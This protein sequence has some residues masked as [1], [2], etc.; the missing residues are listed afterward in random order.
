[1]TVAGVVIGAKVVQRERNLAGRVRAIQDGD[2]PAVT[3]AEDQLMHGQDQRGWRGDMADD[4]N[5]CSLRHASPDLLGQLHVIALWQA[6]RLRAIGRADLFGEEAPG[7]LDRAV[8]M[9]G[10]KHLV[11]WA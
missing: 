2:D 7:A 9:V 5:A 6:D 4:E 11:A 1:V 3:R 10:P 8:L